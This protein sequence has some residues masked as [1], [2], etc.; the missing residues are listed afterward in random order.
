[1]EWVH[2]ALSHASAGLHGVDP[3]SPYTLAA[4]ATTAALVGVA[5]SR[6]FRSKKPR[7]RMRATSIGSSR[8][9][10][11]GTTDPAV[12]PTYDTIINVSVTLE[13]HPDVARLKREFEVEMLH[14]LR[15]RAV[16]HQDVP[17]GEVTWT[18]QRVDLDHHF[19]QH[20]VPTP[21][22][23][24]T[25]IEHVSNALLRDKS[26][27]WWEVH[28]VRVEGQKEGYMVIRIHH[29]LA[30]G[31]SLVEAFAPLLKDKDG[32]ALDLTS[33]F[34][35][36]HLQK[37]GRKPALSTRLL[38]LVG[39][40]VSFVVEVLKVVGLA[41]LPGDKPTRFC[42]S[43]WPYSGPRIAV[44]FPSHSLAL[45]KAMKD[46]AGK[47]TTVN[48]VEFALFAGTIRRFLQ[49]HDPNTDLSR[50]R[51]RALTPL[52]LLEQSDPETKY[53]TMMRNLFTFVVNTL[54]TY[55]AD[56]VERLRASNAM[57]SRLKSSAAVP[58]AFFVH[59][60]TAKLPIAFQRKTLVDLMSRHSV[61]FSNV[62]GAQQPAYVAGSRIVATHMIYPNF[63][64]QVGIVSVDGRVHMCVTM[65]PDNE[66]D[67]RT[68]LPKL[69]REELEATAKALGV[70]M[71]E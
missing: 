41:T 7:R 11:S 10:A 39:F 69:F 59:K 4:A 42:H 6:L 56:P 8:F 23:A 26:K 65:A 3:Y 70:P 19:V 63:T 20:H 32:K 30:D 67:L 27:P 29:A 50:V 44:I 13:S 2:A 71:V 28:T 15:L 55:V 62:P 53:A 58:A 1:M 45:I 25:L 31:V 21:A 47:G 38:N 51:L 61:V 16:P 49:Q 64:P 60:L 22:A 37:G 66:V 68:V 12:L 14:H 33:M 48:D 24:H 18:V 46:K 54:P 43:Q 5:G 36:R 40:P 17:C 57:W 35:P 9:M 34:N 52:A